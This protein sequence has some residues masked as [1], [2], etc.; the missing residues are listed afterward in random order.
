[1]VPKKMLLLW[2]KTVF[3]H[4]SPYYKFRVHMFSKLK[5]R[6]TS[7]SRRISA[8]VSS[9]PFCWR[10]LHGYQPADRQ[11]IIDRRRVTCW[12]YRSIHH[13]THRRTRWRTQRRGQS[14]RQAERQT[15]RR[16][17]ASMVPCHVPLRF[18]SGV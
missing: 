4:W 5:N 18:I 15:E 3:C 8:V 12:L 14:D 13:H 1:M 11:P 10:T 17:N 6:H 7:S 9:P 2:L 16:L